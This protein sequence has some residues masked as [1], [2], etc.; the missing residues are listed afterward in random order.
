MAALVGGPDQ[1]F[2][3]GRSIDTCYVRSV[4]G[5]HAEYDIGKVQAVIDTVESV[6]STCHALKCLEG[7]RVAVVLVEGSGRVHRHEAT[8]HTSSTLR[9]AL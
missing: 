6:R 3:S 4:R 1:N 9:I 8:E 7:G 5:V 2:R